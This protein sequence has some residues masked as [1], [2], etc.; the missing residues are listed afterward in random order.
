MKNKRRTDHL[1]TES[2][3]INTVD[4]DILSTNKILKLISDEDRKISKSIKKEVGNIERAINL[5]YEKLSTGG[6]L[7]LVGAGTSGR[8]AV[9]EAAECPPTFG[10]SPKLIH[11]VIAGGSK[12][13]WKSLEGAEDS[14]DNSRVNLSKL[15]INKKD[16]VLGIAASGSTPFVVTAMEYAKKVKASALMLTFNPVNK[17][18][19]DIIIAPIVGPEV[20]V[21]S[22]RMK[23]GTA[24]KMIL[25][26][27]TTT[28]MIRMGK[29][30]GNLMVD[31]QPKSQKLRNRARKIVKELVGTNYKKAESLLDESDWEVKTAI[32]IGIKKISKI[33]AKRLLANQKGFLRKALD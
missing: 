15:N 19:A 17:K 6:R 4:I 14:Y 2:I 10:T 11:A 9:L 1:I 18:M 28:L 24:T 21:G 32:V 27:I 7:F 3:N 5:I 33:E 13:V 16:V 20:I 22:T 8:L 23:A 25:N 12:A 29:T 31:V 30:Y 26:M